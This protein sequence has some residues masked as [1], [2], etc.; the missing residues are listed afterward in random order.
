MSNIL[1]QEIKNETSK[2]HNIWLEWDMD[3]L[4]RD[5][6]HDLERKVKNSTRFSPLCYNICNVP[7]NR[8]YDELIRVFKK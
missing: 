4:I 2:I 8:L 6:N 5:Y 3:I 1:S 7:L